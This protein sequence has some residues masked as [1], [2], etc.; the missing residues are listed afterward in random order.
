MAD[1]KKSFL[2]YLKQEKLQGK[3]RSYELYFK[4]KLTELEQTIFGITGKQLF[5]IDNV[6]DLEKLLEELSEEKNG[7]IIPLNMAMVFPMP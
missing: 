4:R 6:A 5:E 2:K 1:N 7:V 3:I